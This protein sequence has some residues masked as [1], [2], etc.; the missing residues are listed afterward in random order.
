M[1]PFR[2]CLQMP[3]VR[4][5]QKIETR[6]PKPGI[7]ILGQQ[8]LWLIQTSLHTSKKGP[9]SLGNLHAVIDKQTAVSSQT[10][11][12]QALPTFSPTQLGLC[13][14]IW[15]NGEENGSYWIVQGSGFRIWGI[16]FKE[17]RLTYLQGSF[18]GG[19]LKEEFWSQIDE[20]MRAT[21]SP[22]SFGPPRRFS[23]ACQKEF[24]SYLLCGVLLS[25]RVRDPGQSL[26]V[27][28]TIQCRPPAPYNTH[29]QDATM[30]IWRVND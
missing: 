1:P 2:P 22:A 27:T 5:A 29:P 17:Q 7:L 26:G 25:L 3:E 6:C 20:S 9:L 4:S 15:A 8:H 21:C 30:T 23:Y 19:T 24:R 13:R 16:G 12:L 11:A 14:A 18:K 10:L 28:L